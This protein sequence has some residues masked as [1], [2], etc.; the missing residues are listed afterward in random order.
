ME[1]GLGHVAEAERKSRAFV[2]RSR[3][4]FHRRLTQDGV[5]ALMPL[6]FNSTETEYMVTRGDENRDIVDRPACILS[7]AGRT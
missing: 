3:E 5:Q 6:L 2:C 7:I 1:G 4:A